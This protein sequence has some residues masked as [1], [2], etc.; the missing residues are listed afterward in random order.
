MA[1]DVSG[2]GDGLF[3]VSAADALERPIEALET[4]AAV[5]QL[6]LIVAETAPRRDAKIRVTAPLIADLATVVTRDPARF[7]SVEKLLVAH[8]VSFG[9]RYA[10]RDGVQR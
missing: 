2:E 10:N 1:R 6:R 3:D 4:S 8:V 7:S 9:Q 5:G